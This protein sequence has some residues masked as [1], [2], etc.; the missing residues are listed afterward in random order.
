M[1]FPQQYQPFQQPMMPQTRMVEVVPVDTV[2]A[3]RE[4]PVAIGATVIMIAKDDSF[5][6]VKINGVNG[7]SSF[8]V[9][10]KRPPAP[11]APV[12][13]PSAFVT[14]EELESRLT[15]ILKPR[16]GEE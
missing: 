14:K 3:A 13:D 9:Y 4:F 8:E 6:A 12:F 15:A 11:P 7:Q 16:K 10:D 2:D 1:Y 5:M